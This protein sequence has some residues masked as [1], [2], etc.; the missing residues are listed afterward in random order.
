MWCGYQSGTLSRTP[1]PSSGAHYTDG[2]GLSKCDCQDG[3]LY[4][5]GDNTVQA[6]WDQCADSTPTITATA[7]A[8]A[9]VP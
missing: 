5:I 8:T 4:C 7:T 9:T 3:T 1:G 2:Q 6:C